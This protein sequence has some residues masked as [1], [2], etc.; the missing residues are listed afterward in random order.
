[1]KYKKI[2]L[3]GKKQSKG[4]FDD[5]FDTEKYDS[6][7]E[8]YDSNDFVK[9]NYVKD[10]KGII[11]IEAQHTKKKNKKYHRLMIQNCPFGIDIN[12]DNYAAE[13][14]ITLF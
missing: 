1:M 13:L 2:D 10:K 14:A 6:V 8:A 7:K 3:F 11:Y 12:D 4:S 5:F 9:C